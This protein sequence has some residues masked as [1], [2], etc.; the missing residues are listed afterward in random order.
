MWTGFLTL[1]TLISK[2]CCGNAEEFT[3]GY[4]TGSQ[5]L[6]EDYYYKRPGRTISG[7]ITMAIEEVNQNLL[8]PKGHSL[9]FKVNFLFRVE[10]FNFSNF[11]I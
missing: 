10:N 3:V 2:L 1:F 8:N 4:L 9:K 6:P 5:R 11:L 7:A